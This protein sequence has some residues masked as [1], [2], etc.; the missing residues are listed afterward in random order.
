MAV[1]MF[2]KIDDV[3]GE[4][5]DSA[6]K[7]EIDVYSWSWG[8]TQT[9]SAGRGGSGSGVGR[10]N[11]QDFTFTTKV[12][13][14]HA[15]LLGMTL[16][17]KPFKTAIFTQ[18][19][20]GDKPLEFVKITMSNGHITRVQFTKDAND[21]FQTVAVDLNF[22]QVKFDYT[23]Q[24]ADGSGGATITYGHDIAQNVPM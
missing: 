5:L 1:D 3:K 22:A 4:S 17:A 19:K 9:G 10:A 15:V 20:A 21:E 12:D 24:A 2:M 8:V 13:S 7:G 14:A 6:H 16:R 18:R 23:P 11:V